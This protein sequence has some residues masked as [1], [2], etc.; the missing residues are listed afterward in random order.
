MICVFYYLSLLVA[1]VKLE[2]HQ[3]KNDSSQKATVSNNTAEVS[4]KTKKTAVQQDIK[5]PACDGEPIQPECAQWL[6]DTFQKLDAIGLHDKTLKARYPEAY[7]PGHVALPKIY[8]T[9]DKIIAAVEQVVSA[10][11]VKKY[12][13]SIKQYK[14]ILI[15]RYEDCGGPGERFYTSKG[16][17]FIVEELD[18]PVEPTKV[19]FIKGKDGRWLLNSDLHYG[20]RTEP[21]IPKGSSVTFTEILYQAAP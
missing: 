18:C 14:D 16:E 15:T 3:Q 5:K 2:T 11:I 21:A 9:P 20:C 19:E 12:L 1:C 10:K 13:S 7:A 6:Y 17:W 8:N 4:T